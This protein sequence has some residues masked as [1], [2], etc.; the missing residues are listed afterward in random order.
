MNNPKGRV[1]WIL[2]RLNENSTLSY[3]ECWG[4]HSSKWNKSGK[5][6]D[7]DWKKAIDLFTTQ[8]EQIKQVSRLALSDAIKSNIQSKH[9]N[10][11]AKLLEIINK[12]ITIE[13]KCYDMT[14]G[15]VVV[16]YREPSAMEQIEAIKEYNRIN[17]I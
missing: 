14:I 15:K 10:M 17:G 13:E 12:K 4:I 5:T 1:E 2:S 9:S 16:F 6:F 8:Q 11:C 3:T 7:T